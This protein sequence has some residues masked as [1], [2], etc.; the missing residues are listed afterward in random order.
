VIDDGLVTPRHLNPHID[1]DA[2][3][4]PAGTSESSLAQPLGMAVTSD[5]GTLFV[6]AYGSSAI[7]VID[8]H[9]LETG[10]LVPTPD[11]LIDLGDPGPVGPSGLVLDETRGR[12]Y[13]VTR[14]D[15]SVVTVDM[16]SREVLARARMHTPEPAHVVTGRPML[17]AA[18]FTS[19]NGEASCGSCHI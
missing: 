4:T 14:F 16:G 13:V 8:T 10:A 12:L 3:P 11:R 17:Y 7:G 15:N 18:R 1:Y 5:G 9:E 6:A 2:I 19:S